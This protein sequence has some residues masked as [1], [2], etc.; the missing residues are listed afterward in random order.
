MLSFLFWRIIL[1]ILGVIIGILMTVRPDRF[2]NFFG[3]S[4]FAEEL[5]DRG[6]IVGGSMSWYQILGIIIII[7]SFLSFFGLTG[8]IITGFFS[9]FFGPR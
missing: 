2:L 7:F 8:R 5:R 9:I 3:R 6:L 4:D 1:P